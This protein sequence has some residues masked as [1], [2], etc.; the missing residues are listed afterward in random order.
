MSGTI[1]IKIP[2]KVYK[3]LKATKDK[4]GINMT[5]LVEFS[6]EEYKKKQKK[7]KKGA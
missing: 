3:E 7:A 1:T 4:T 6:W 5:K 2:V